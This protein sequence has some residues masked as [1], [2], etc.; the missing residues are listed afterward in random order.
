MSCL[1]TEAMLGCQQCSL[2]KHRTQ[3]VPGHGSVAARIAFVCEAPGAEEDAQGEPLVGRAGQRFNRQLEAAGLRREDVWLDNAVHCRP[4]ANDLKR[5]P[6]ALVTCP[7]LWLLPTLAKL[8]NLRVVIA[9]GATAGS[10]WFPGYGA[11]IIANLGRMTPDGYA[12]IGSFHP[13]YAM[14][15]GGDWNDVDASIVRSIGR[16][17]TYVAITEASSG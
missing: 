13:S 8:A 17:L 16:A 3:V 12:V 7:P 4:P 11:T 2:A 5:A 14:R 10:L 6:D 1:A 15:S 9:M